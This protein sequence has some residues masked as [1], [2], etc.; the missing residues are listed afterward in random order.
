MVAVFNFSAVGKMGNCCPCFK[1]KSEEGNSKNRDHQPRR[2]NFHLLS[3]AV[4][5]TVVERAPLLPH[6]EEY[7][8]EIDSA[9]EFNKADHY[10]NVVDMA[11]R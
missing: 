3:S 2:I 1:S 5:S 7:S 11:Q 9:K 4:E 8:P 10:Q 6:E